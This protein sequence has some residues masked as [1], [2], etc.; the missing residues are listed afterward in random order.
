MGIKGLLMIQLRNRIC[1]NSDCML[2]SFESMVYKAN[3]VYDD[4]WV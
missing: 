2:F 4:V 1:E 3:N